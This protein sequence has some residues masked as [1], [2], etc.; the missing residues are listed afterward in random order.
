MMAQPMLKQGSVAIT[1]V[2]DRVL[3]QLAQGSHLLQQKLFRSLQEFG[4]RLEDMQEAGAFSGP[5]NWSLSMRLLSFRGELVIRVDRYDLSVLNPAPEEGDLLRKMLESIEAALMS[6]TDDVGIKNRHFAYH[7]H[8]EI[9]EGYQSVTSQ[10]VPHV[11]DALGSVTGTGVSFY[12][13]DSSLPGEASVVLDR[14]ILVPNGLFV[15]ARCT[16]GSDFDLGPS[17]ANFYSYLTKA[18]G[19]FGLP[20]RQ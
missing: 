5:A 12:M 4:L 6:S 18:L 3:F 13:T 16:F 9:P 10:F 11:P 7:G 8:N 20:V 19:V 17:F 15:T 1:G 2:L 14:S